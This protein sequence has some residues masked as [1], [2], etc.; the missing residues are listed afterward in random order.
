MP[1]PIKFSRSNKKSEKFQVDGPGSPRAPLQGSTQMPGSTQL[2]GS[3]QVQGSS[4]AQGS[5]QRQKQSSRPESKQG[6]SGSHPNQYGPKM[7]SGQARS[8]LTSPLPG[9]SAVLE[10]DDPQQTTVF[11]VMIMATMVAILYMMYIMQEVRWR[12]AE[13]GQQNLEL[14]IQQFPKNPVEYNYR[15]MQSFRSGDTWRRFNYRNLAILAGTSVSFTLMTR[16]HHKRQEML[17][18]RKTLSFWLWTCGAGLVGTVY[19]VYLIR[20]STGPQLLK[21]IRRNPAARGFLYIGAIVL[22][23]MVIYVYMLS[24]RKS[25]RQKI[26]EAWRKKKHMKMMEPKSKRP[27]PT[28]VFNKPVEMDSPLAGQGGGVNFPSTDHVDHNPAT[29]PETRPGE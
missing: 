7:D 1:R 29:L 9:S 24:G 25:K 22:V 18:R 12:R 6:S 17:A 3:T 21:E 20:K 14:A 13:R 15:Q 19:S 16:W 28:E 27:D 8:A 5:T 23:S 26:L 4:K 11:W 10:V 2:P